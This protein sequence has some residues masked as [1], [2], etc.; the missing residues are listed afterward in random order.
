MIHVRIYMTVLFV[1]VVHAV[2][3]GNI[4]W[5][6]GYIV[7]NSDTLHGELAFRDGN[8]DWK[9]CMFRQHA[10]AEM[11][12]FAPDQLSAYGYESGLNYVSKQIELYKIQGSFFVQVLLLGNMSLYYLDIY[13]CNEY[14]KGY[15]AYIIE[16][17]GSM[18]EMMD[19]AKSDNRTIVQRQNKTKLKMLFGEYPDLA[20]DIDKVGSNRDNWIG[21]FQKYHVITC[22]DYS[23]LMYQ[24]KKKHKRWLITPYIG[25]SSSRIPVRNFK[26]F[27]SWYPEIGGVA[28]YN[29]S[30]FSNR[31]LFNIGLEFSGSK[32]KEEKA[33][34]FSYYD[35]QKK[36][37][38][39]YGDIDLHVMRLT[40]YF[41]I[42]YRMM[43]KAVQPFVEFGFFHGPQLIRQNSL[44]TKATLGLKNDFQI[45][46]YQVGI[47][48][49]A[50]V[51][52]NLKDHQIPI[53]FQY[54]WPLNMGG[55]ETTNQLSISAI[56]VISLSVGYT[57][58]IGN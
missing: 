8:G 24:E 57:F 25:A 10:N 2:F 37:H 13:P 47:L 43:N 54:R 22:N 3:A 31:Y 46:S 30:K 52:V 7:Q 40:N 20:N 44:K 45:S 53:R 12:S 9:V 36:Y 28:S 51:I 33:L 21:L 39:I 35:E 26:T 50:G 16:R 23:C 29:L 32:L 42:E 4:E 14:P 58:K 56:S 15:G 6:K 11:Q 5:Q 38:E 17:P 49:G 55:Q 19:P 34:D 27:G 18:I 41:S 1:C 48:G